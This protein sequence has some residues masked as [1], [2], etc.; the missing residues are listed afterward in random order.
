[1]NQ[2]FCSSKSQQHLSASTFIQHFT[3]SFLN[4]LQL[5]ACC[6][7]FHYYTAF[8]LCLERSRN[9]ICFF[10]SFCLYITADKNVCNCQKKSSSFT[11]SSFSSF[12][13]SLLWLTAVDHLPPPHPIPYIHDSFLWYSSFLFCLAVP[14]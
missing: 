9:A 6:F 11:D 7:H 8:Q 14:P 10:F 1:M 2:C 4:S 3:L 13:S 12:S 5:I